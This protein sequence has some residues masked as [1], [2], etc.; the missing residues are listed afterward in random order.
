MKN[1]FRIRLPLIQMYSNRIEGIDSEEKDLFIPRVVGV[2]NVKIDM[3]IW[4]YVDFLKI[5]SMIFSLKMKR[6]EKKSSLK[7][8]LQMSRQQCLL[9]K[10]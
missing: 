10:N 1:N 8:N 9:D 7:I 2:I 5:E 3:D 4:I 6:E